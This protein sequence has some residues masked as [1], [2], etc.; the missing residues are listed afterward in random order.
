MNYKDTIYFDETI[1]YELSSSALFTVKD[2]VDKQTRKN[3][4][5]YCPCL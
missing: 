2:K 4:Q 1:Q 5:Q 3:T